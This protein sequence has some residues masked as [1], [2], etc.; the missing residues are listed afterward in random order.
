MNKEA[1]GLRNHI[2]QAKQWYTI[3]TKTRQEEIAK[4][5]YQ[6]QG[7]IVYLP[8]LRKTVR[9]ARRTSEKVVPFFPG[10]LFLQL[11]ASDRNWTTIA[12]TRGSL[13]ALCF[14]DTYVPVPDWVIADLKEREDNNS[15]IPIVDLMK[16]KLVPGSV[17]TINLTGEENTQGIVYSS[18]GSANVDV[19]LTILGRQVKATVALDRI[20]SD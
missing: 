13:G 15:N 11:S 9:H 10:Y 16:D 18:R 17:V 2:P 6:R 8:K 19:L 20:E 7:Y 3:R 1:I 4:L 5:N 12:S 14:G